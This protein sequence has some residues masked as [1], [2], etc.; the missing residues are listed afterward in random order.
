MKKIILFASLLLCLLFLSPAFAQIPHL[1]NYQ[2]K[3]TDTGG[4]P[5]ADGNHSVTFRIYDADAGGTLLWEETQSTLIQK[6]IFSCLLGGVTNLDLPFDEP[7]WLAVKVGNDEEMT[8]RQQITSAG[9]AIR[10]EK[11]ENVTVPFFRSGLEV[12]F[13]DSKHIKVAP[14]ALDI[15]GRMS[16]VTAYSAPIG[17]DAGF[18]YI[19]GN[20]APF[21]S[22]SYVYVRRNNGSLVY[23]LSANPPNKAD[24]K[25]NEA[26]RKR[27]YTQD[28]AVYYRCVG[29][30][31]KN[32]S[33]NVKEVGNVREGDVPNIVKVV[34]TSEI[35][36]PSNS[37]TD[38]DDMLI[39]FVSSGRPVRITGC[40]PISHV[41]GGS[42]IAI[43]IDGMHKINQY[44]AGHSQAYYDFGQ[45]TV[46]WLEVLPAGSHVIKL[47]WKS[48]ASTC[49]QHGTTIGA[50]IMTVEEL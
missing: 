41:N 21:N 23:K 14:G 11:V 42:Y 27:Y 46:M 7:Y 44:Q 12:E 16:N 40:M 30:F 6:G 34:G 43:N 3:L 25:G 48:N 1:I 49:K 36:C 10:A 8:P 2:G 37:Y 35:S 19:N 50:R 32:S 26:G 13:A 22:W 4:N 18:N 29:W 28:G 33:G 20:T 47:Q 15:A 45:E 9:Y 5:V 17:I 24:H 31:Y 39:H 38:M